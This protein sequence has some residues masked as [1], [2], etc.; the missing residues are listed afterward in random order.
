MRNAADLRDT[1]LKEGSASMVNSL[2]C[3]AKASKWFAES[4]APEVLSFAQTLLRIITNANVEFSA[5]NAELILG[6]IGRETAQL[7]KGIARSITCFA[8]KN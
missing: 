2:V 8:P 6:F 4:A 1:C 3:A 5:N 7:G